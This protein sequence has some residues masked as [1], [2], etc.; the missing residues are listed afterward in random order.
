MITSTL[1][2]VDV[3]LLIYMFPTPALFIQ[4]DKDGDDKF[5]IVSFSAFLWA[6]RQDDATSEDLYLAVSRIQYR[7][8]VLSET[9]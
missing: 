3:M 4:K 1:C 5:P 2:E 8:C 6:S 7:A 9:Q